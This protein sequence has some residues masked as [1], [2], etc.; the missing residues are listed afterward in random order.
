MAAP[1]ALYTHRPP[2]PREFPP[3]R[4]ENCFDQ[5]GKVGKVALTILVSFSTYAFLP[6]TIATGCVALATLASCIYL[7]PCCE[8]GRS[9]ELSDH[10]PMRR[11]RVVIPE[12]ILRLPQ[13]ISF[14]QAPLAHSNA[15]AREPL[16]QQVLPVPVPVP[17]RAPLAHG[18]VRARESLGQ[19]A[20]VP[21]RVP[22]REAPLPRHNTGTRE[23]LRQQA[24]VPGPTPVRA[25]LAHGNV[26]AREPLGQQA[27]VPGP[28]PVRTPLAHGNVRAR[29][30]ARTS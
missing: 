1:S 18:N 15:R 21:E 10:L 17:V 14:E 27:P 8:T 4:N 16:G 23:P 3:Q 12:S 7:L 2:L 28:M 29:E 13:W 26:R 20:P 19:Q 24:P 25:P 30:L 9:S 22:I 11:S 6:W 5:I